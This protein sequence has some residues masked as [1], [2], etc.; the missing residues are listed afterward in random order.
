[1]RSIFD[2]RI[3]KLFVVTLALKVLSS[4]LGW[5]FQL[6]WSF[7]FWIPI[8]LMSAYIVLG[9][10]RRDNEVSDEKFADSCYYLGFIFTITSIIFSLFDLPNI[11]TRIQE[12]A[13]RFGAAMVSTVLGLGVRVYLVSFRKE[14]AD[15]IKDAEDGIIEASQRF[16]M[17]LVIAFDKLRDF[18]SQ[19]D[20]AAKGTV[21]RVNMQVE[22]LSKN[23]A[24]KLT[25]FFTD[26]TN[27]NQEAFTEALQEVKTASLKLSESVDGYSLGMRENLTSIEA[28]VGAFTDAV[29][30]R[31]RTTTFPDDYFAKRL[32]APLIH[33]ETSAHDLSAGVKQASIAVSE[34]SMLLG[35]ALKKMRDKASATEKSL[36]IVLT[37]TAQQQAVLDSTQGQLNVLERL[38][39]TL[40]GFDAVL[41]NTLKGL[42]TSNSVTSELTNRVALVVTEGAE[43][44]DVLEASLAEIIDKLGANSTAT[45]MLATKFETTAIAGVSIAGKLATNAAASELVASK[46]DSVANADLETAKTLA[47]LSAGAI[48]A[49]SKVDMAME[50]LQGMVQQLSALDGALR[51]QSNEL[52]QVAERIK[53]VTVR[54][55]LPPSF[56]V[57]NS[58]VSPVTPFRQSYG[59]TL[60]IIPVTSKELTALTSPITSLREPVG[61]AYLLESAVSAS[62]SS[63]TSPNAI[64][65]SVFFE[66]QTPGRG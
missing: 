23:H 6:P 22:A 65:T 25:S 20:T 33:L 62:P 56:G 52:T 58:L 31:L 64:S 45:E 44:R 1:M 50:Q 27:R 29:T 16:Q 8:T 10:K 2:I 26:L 41:S 54:G 59:P 42:H 35:G 11:G 34:S 38:G 47:A 15:A 4:G 32:E 13:V 18:E 66:P 39:I 21:E 24:D 61:Q 36:D 40:I 30:D 43:A 3:Q 51:A 48:T 14:V 7:G 49:V 12:I 37:L 55:E 17:Q 57:A 19:V 63:L 28:K 9:I 53:D 46:L 60:P 5:Y